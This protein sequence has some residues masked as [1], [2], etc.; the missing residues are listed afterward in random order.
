MLLVLPALSHPHL[1]IISLGTYRWSSIP[2]AFSQHTG[3][4]HTPPWGSL[5]LRDCSKTHPLF[6]RAGA[7]L[8]GWTTT[9]S[10]TDGCPVPGCH[11]YGQPWATPWLRAPSPGRRAVGE[12]RVRVARAA[13]DAV[14]AAVPL[15]TDSGAQ[16]GLGQGPGSG[17]RCKSFDVVCSVELFAGAAFLLG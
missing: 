4:G 5:D 12:H 1:L 10:S 2:P 16:P 9:R 17:E 6:A 13:E 11:G 3:W 15:R 14:A 8:G 7:T